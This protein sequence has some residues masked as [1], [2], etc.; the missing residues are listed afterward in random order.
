MPTIQN[1]KVVYQGGEALPTVGSEAYLSAQAGNIPTTGQSFTAPATDTPITTDLLSSGAQPFKITDPKTSTGLQ[2]IGA[3]VTG[4]GQ[5]D[6]TAYTES[7][8]T[9]LKREELAK[10]GKSIAD[11][12]TE[13]KTESQLQADAYSD[14]NSLGTS[15]DSTG[16]LL[17]NTNAKINAIDVAANAEIQNISKNFTGTLSGR[18]NAIGEVQRKASLDKAN[19]YIDKLMQEGDYTSAKELADRVVTAQLEQQKNDLAA[20]MF[21]YEENKELF[22]KTEQREFEAY[23]KKQD[24]ELQQKEVDMKNIS[25]LAI[26]ARKNG[27]PTAVAN[28]I[29]QAKTLNEAIQIGLDYMFTPEPFEVPTV[30][31][32]NGVDMQFNKSSGQWEPVSVSATANDESKNKTLTQLSFLR[33]TAGKAKNLS[34]AAGASGIARFV[35]DTFVGDTKFR[36][37]ENFTD[38]LRVNILSLMT[39]PTIKKF[40]GP[41]MS[42]ADVKLMTSAG[43]TLNPGQ[44]TQKQIEDEIERLDDLFNRMST[45]VELGTSQ[46]QNLITS[47]TGEVIQITD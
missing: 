11:L 5:A 23:S 38:T 45:A 40:F 4:L 28:K 43:T 8:A 24:R 16:R 31:T 36:Q 30:K 13:G 9:R 47:P 19:L 37:L 17:R 1:G 34:G 6:Q 39:D 27:A 42:N 18:Q 14:T 21:T 46:T 3:E 10:Q 22:T 12:M 25:E 7:E 41:Q 35:G 29:L 15:V 26:N 44:N 20:K 2:Q 32:I 33:E